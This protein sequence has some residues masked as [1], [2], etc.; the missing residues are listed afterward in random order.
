MHEY[1]LH[2]AH[3]VPH[4]LERLAADGL[5]DTVN[6]LTTKITTLL[7]TVA[8]LVGA[9]LVVKKGW[10][11]KGAPGA[12]IGA[13]IM[14]GVLVFVVRNVKWF[15]DRV[16]ADVKIVSVPAVRLHS[17]PDRIHLSGHEVTWHGRRLQ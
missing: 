9:I 12:I 14:A 11:S 1:L 5:T 16:S 15:E 2:S 6:N 3:V 13:G 4:V 17:L 8:T 10:E 7:I